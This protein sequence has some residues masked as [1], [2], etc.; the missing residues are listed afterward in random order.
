MDPE[1]Q[2]NVIAKFDNVL[3]NRFDFKNNIKPW[4][5]IKKHNFSKNSL[6]LK[7]SVGGLQ[8]LSECEKINGVDQNVF[9]KKKTVGYLWRHRASNEAVDPFGQRTKEWILET[10]SALF[11][12]LIKDYNAHI[13]IAGMGR[14]DSVSD[15]KN[16]LDVSGF[17]PGEYKIKYTDSSLDLPQESCTYLKGIGYAAEIEIMSRC[18]LLLMMPS[19]FSEILWM[20]QKNPVLLLDSPPAY[21]LKLMRYRMPF[22]NNN[23]FNYFCFNNFTKHTARNV[24]FF[25][26]GE[27][28]L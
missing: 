3:R 23:K 21:L 15:L 4:D 7:L 28:L 1:L 18:D 11:R 14:K 2:C 19:G 6:E 20:K 8:Y 5:I 10:K 12:Q 9:L 22:F 13:I 27:G 16:A 24:V 17:L 25:I 26:R